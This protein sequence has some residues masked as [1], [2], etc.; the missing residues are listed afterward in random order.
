MAERQTDIRYHKLKISIEYFQDVKLGLKKYEIREYTGRDFR[1]GDRLVLYCPDL[2][3]PYLVTS[4]IN[5]ML[6]DSDFPGIA[7]SYVVLSF[8]EAEVRS[9]SEIDNLPDNWV[10]VEPLI[11]GE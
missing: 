4:P 5:Y 1:I 6:Y 7:A 10:E 8:E 2:F 11:K 9:D 3:C